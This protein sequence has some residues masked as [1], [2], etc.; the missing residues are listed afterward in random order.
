MKN[1][2]FYLGFLGGFLCCALVMGIGFQAAGANRNITI[3]DNIKVEFNGKAFTPKDA[4][5]RTVPVFA[6]DGTTYAPIRAL[7]EAAGM[8][9][10]YDSATR[11]AKV[12]AQAQTAPSPSIG[13]RPTDP[14]PVDPGTLP[15]IMITEEEAKTIALNHAGLQSSEV[16][17]I[18][19]ELDHPAGKY[20]V[21]FYCGK[22]EYEYHIGVTTGA[23]LKVDYDVRGSHIPDNSQSASSED[24]PAEQAKEI[25]LEHAGL[26]AS[27]AV[28]VRVNIDYE[29]SRRIYEVEFY[30]GNTEYDYKLDAKTGKILSWDHDVEDFHIPGGSGTDGYI[31]EARAKEIAL[32]RLPSGTVTKCKLDH[33]G[34]RAVYKLELR[35]GRDEF[36]CKIDAQTGELLKW[37]IDH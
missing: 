32:E 22:I 7:C 5:G 18:E 20:E 34:G 19:V 21:E 23:I 28:F 14:G 31:G 2:K 35:A 15:A 8:D 26:S 13:P 16:T 30:A 1:K 11:T 12:T 37:E 24:I 29:D 9:V 3:N 10:D 4:N 17:F 6:Y 25:V 33:S 36:E 27:G